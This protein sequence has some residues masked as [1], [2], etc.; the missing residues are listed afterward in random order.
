[1]AFYEPSEML[2]QQFCTL[3]I[4]QAITFLENLS[5]LDSSPSLLTT[6]DVFEHKS[7]IIPNSAVGRHLRYLSAVTSD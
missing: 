3:V 7:Q 6:K 4:E 2:T 1:M 5:T